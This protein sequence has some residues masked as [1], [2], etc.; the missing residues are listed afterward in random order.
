MDS[1]V[2]IEIIGRDDTKNL[3]EQDVERIS[4]DMDNSNGDGKNGSSRSNWHHKYGSG[5]QEKT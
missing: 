4:V 1:W 2:K 5:K 3:E